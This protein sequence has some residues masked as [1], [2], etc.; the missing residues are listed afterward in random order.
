MLLVLSSFYIGSFIFYKSNI[1]ISERR[2]TGKLFWFSLTIKVIA[3]FFNYYFFNL[4][5]GQPNMF[6]NSDGVF[7]HESGL[8]VAENFANGNFDFWNFLRHDDLSDAGGPL[9]YGIIYLLTGN[10]SNIII[11]RLFNAIFASLSVIVFYKI[12]RYIND[13]KIARLA[14]S[15]FLFFPI[16]NL[17]AGLHLKETIF[18]Y[19]LL[20]TILKAHKF[21]LNKSITLGDL[22]IFAFTFVSLFLFRSFTGIL[23]ISSMLL[24]LIFRGKNLLNIQTLFGLSLFFIISIWFFSNYFYQ[25]TQSTLLGAEKS[26]EAVGSAD[27]TRKG[28][29]SIM[30]NLISTPFMMVA[31]LPAPTPTIVN[32][33][34]EREDTL[35]MFRSIAPD[36]FIKGFLAF[37]VII[38]LLS[39]FK[40]NFRK[41]SFILFFFIF[42]FLVIAISGYS[43]NIRYFMPL[44]PFF[45]YFA[46]IGLQR[47][48]SYKKLYIIY[49]ISISAI[50]IY[51]NY[52]KLLD[53]GVLIN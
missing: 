12:I 52:L 53:Y 36:S 10:F 18:I 1:N 44:L 48:K 42:Y 3:V 45:I 6:A 47:F 31:A 4:M 7:Y 39:L 24:F 17:Y 38:G 43:F 13:I 32:Y 25:E 41:N 21:V 22:S 23:V 46:I 19:L 33:R 49:L 8:L 20:V 14:S 2:F 51:Y 5:N 40:K 34:A 11:G 37:W 28:S 50:T 26:I 30:T 16:F 29:K 9:Y 35:T 27:E 15:I